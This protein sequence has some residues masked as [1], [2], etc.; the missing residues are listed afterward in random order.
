MSGQ[1]LAHHR[2]KGVATQ[3]VCSAREIEKLEFNHG[4]HHL[5]GRPFR[6]GKLEPTDGAL[7]F[8]VEFEISVCGHHKT[9][10]ALIDT[11]AQANLICGNIFPDEVWKRAQHPM[12]LMAANGD[13]FSG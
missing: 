3:K 8:M 10:Q 4:W 12:A 11:G 1:Q 9:I 5:S 2:R 6:V 13:V 7:Q